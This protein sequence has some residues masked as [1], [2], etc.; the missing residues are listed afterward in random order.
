MMVLKIMISFLIVGI[1]T[2]IGFFKAGKLKRREYVLKDMIRFLNMLENELKYM[3]SMLPNA[4][5]SA[6]QGLNTDLKL[7]IGQIVVDMLTFETT[8]AVDKS[9]CNNIS[10]INEL[11][12]YDKN[13]IISTL[14]NLGRSDLDS[15][16]NIIENCKNVLEEQIK[17]ANSLKL[18]NSKMYKT[19]GVIT[20][21]MIVVI[22]I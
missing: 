3:M 9:I 17:E 7:Y 20:G 16:I 15:Q 1:T 21:I 6:R 22:F 10:K 2:Y 8:D 14:K 18:T 12:N 11:T 4:Y 5:E 13:I 19:V